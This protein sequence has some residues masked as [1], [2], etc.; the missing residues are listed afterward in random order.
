MRFLNYF[1]LLVFLLVPDSGYA[2]EWR[3]YGLSGTAV[4]GI[5]AD[6]TREQCVLVGYTLI[7][8]S[9]DQGR[10]WQEMPPLPSG[11][12]PQDGIILDASQPI[13]LIAATRGV[14][15]WDDEANNW[16]ARNEGLP[17]DVYCYDLSASGT[18][19]VF[20]GC[21][22]G[23]YYSD[24]AGLHWTNVPLAWGE[25]SVE[26]A[27]ADKE[28]SVYIKVMNNNN[29]FR[30]ESDLVTHT[31]LSGSVG[32]PYPAQAPG[33]VIPNPDNADQ[34]LVVTD[35]LA[36]GKVYYSSNRGATW[37]VPS[38][39]TTPVNPVYP[40]WLD[41]KPIVF[42]DRAVYELNPQSQ[43]W[44]VLWTRI[45]PDTYSVLDLGENDL[46]LGSV[47]RGVWRSDNRGSTW[48]YSSDGMRNHGQVRALGVAADKPET[49][50]V[51]F[52]S[53]GLWRT[54]DDGKTWTEL[55]QG[56]E[57]DDN[58]GISI[59]TL[60]INPRDSNHLIAGTE[61][62]AGQT[63]YL[64]YSNNGGQSWTQIATSPGGP[65][66]RIY[67]VRK[68]PGVVLVGT[69]GDAIWRSTNNGVTFTRVENPNTFRN[70]MDFAEEINGRIFAALIAGFERING[71]A[72]SNDQG[73]TW[74]AV[75]TYSTSSL[76]ADPSRPG[77]IMLGSGSAWM[78]SGAGM[79]YSS[80]NGVTWD[81]VNTDLPYGIYFQTY[82]AAHRTLA[83]PQRSGT[84]YLLMGS[85]GVFRT[86]NDGGSWSQLGSLRAQE[87]E[88][89]PRNEGTLFLGHG[90]Q[91]VLYS[92]LEQPL[93]TL[94]PTPTATAT[95][96]P[97]PTNTPPIPPSPTATPTQP[98]FRN[99][100]IVSESISLSPISPVVGDQVR[101]SG[102]VYN[103]GSI[104]LSQVTVD[105]YLGQDHDNLSN[106]NRVVIAS[107]PARTRVQVQSSTLFPVSS[108]GTY[109][110][111]VVVDRDGAIAESDE[112]DNLAEI[113]FYAHTP[114]ADTQPPTG[115][116][117]IAGG[118]LFTTRDEV[119]LD[120]QATDND[121]GVKWM[122]LT[123]WAYDPYQ[124]EF[125]PYFISDWRDYFTP[126]RFTLWGA[127][128]EAISVNYADADG[129]VSDTYWGFINYTPS[130]YTTYVWYDSI[131]WY[132]Y[133]L[134]AGAQVTL[135]AQ[136]TWGDADLFV[137][138]PSTPPG[139]A[140][141]SSQLDGTVSENISFTAPETGF[142]WVGVYGYLDAAYTL[143]GSSAATG[144]PESL[145]VQNTALS[146]TRRRPGLTTVPK[147]PLLP[148]QVRVPALGWDL[149]NDGRQTFQDTFLA[150]RQ[151]GLSAGDPGYDARLGS[152]RPHQPIGATH[153]MQW[154]RLRKSR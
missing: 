41:G 56:F 33:V 124:N 21:G 81:S 55:H 9:F 74:T 64:Y 45:I 26:R 32:F 115:S 116:I 88:Y 10:T 23:V 111:R 89:S 117:R 138:A 59:R 84:Y 93:P 24:D 136:V 153:L 100:G 46:L 7:Y 127:D 12:L 82:D 61:V 90:T 34:L 121:S 128:L 77:R 63:P 83:H 80:D 42:A 145:L 154:M 57:V 69:A 67:F 140:A 5:I 13:L 152:V 40:S 54:Q 149:N 20:L 132:T 92:Q 134:N 75:E 141:W 25:R 35:A 143:I 14:Y 17:S 113:S 28:G 114:G 3:D 144:K 60:A 120:L 58:L 65:A 135:T 98:P 36:E 129:N 1:V 53:Q 76:A 125:F 96:T 85:K 108:Q 50:Y 31:F 27:E 151:W 62:T 43:S 147:T 78:D 105:F 44:S 37:S 107:L 130:G 16:S 133:Y 102:R 52:H 6:A 18:G 38:G 73:A 66:N 137:I 87:L 146:E 4:R 112:T 99:A 148:D 103:N 70:V 94:T 86:T 101:I 118:S 71:Y 97:I 8:R 79:F 95:R 106:P 104:D 15:L 119:Y 72:Y 68:T 39:G 123:A 47:G 48:T 49:L 139:S 30:I 142:Y 131:N 51:S 91:G 2:L 19:R 29:I 22:T 150:A 126:A 110:A 122:Y 11:Q 109:Y